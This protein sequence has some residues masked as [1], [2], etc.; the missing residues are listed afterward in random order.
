MK[1]AHRAGAEWLLLVGF[2]LGSP[3]NPTIAA[4]VATDWGPSTDGLSLRVVA[5]SDSVDS[6]GRFDC[7]IQF[8]AERSD[9]RAGCQ[10]L[11]WSAPLHQ[12]RLVLERIDAGQDGFI[13]IDVSEFGGAPAGE[14]WLP[15]REEPE[16]RVASPF[17]TLLP[18]G[19][20]IPAGDYRAYVGYRNPG[21]DRRQVRGDD[22]RTIDIPPNSTWS[23][24]VRSSSFVLHVR[25]SE[26]QTRR[27]AIPSDLECIDDEPFRSELSWHWTEFDSM[28]FDLLPGHEFLID[29]TYR[30]L[31]DGEPILF[32]S[33]GEWLDRT[34]QRT[35]EFA[36][37]Q[38][39]GG[40][41][42]T[43]GG[44]R[45]LDNTYLVLA[46]AD[47]ALIRLLAERNGLLEVHFVLYQVVP[48]RRLIDNPT[49]RPL[50]ERTF[51]EPIPWPVP[52][53]PRGRK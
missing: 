27:L 36:L 50:F 21:T 37:R 47:P 22:C 1:R 18:S 41:R 31:M 16:F 43:L 52:K 33:Q 30:V 29:T 10:G 5:A 40:D 49:R 13:L 17:S 34:S 6:G 32:P 7:E 20:P 45:I 12:K 44:P 46:P 2:A 51:V 53:R 24:D 19:R 38:K 35:P 3:T 42:R 11:F 26:A 23:G 9:L 25:P 28:S 8:H 15:L 4:P 48:R 39:F 14:R